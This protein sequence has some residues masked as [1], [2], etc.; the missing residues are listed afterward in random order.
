MGKRQQLWTRRGPYLGPRER[1]SADAGIDDSGSMMRVSLAHET[2]WMLNLQ[3]P[4]GEQDTG[5]RALVSSARHQQPEA[6]RS[7]RKTQAC[8][9]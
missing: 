6:F 5:A 3:P 4:C 9:S 7:M 1:P 8:V 2:C